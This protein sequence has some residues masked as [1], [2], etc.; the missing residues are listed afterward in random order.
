MVVLFSAGRML[1]LCCLMCLM[2]LVDV[3]K[4]LGEVERLLGFLCMIFSFCH[5]FIV[6]LVVLMSENRRVVRR[7][8]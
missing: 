4:G 1:G 3:Y 5:H 8:M 6:V 7:V 2:V